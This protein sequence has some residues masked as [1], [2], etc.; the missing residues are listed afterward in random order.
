MIELIASIFSEGDFI[1]I[2]FNNSNKSVEGYIFKLLP[3]S[4]A[5][6]TLEGKLCGIKGE[7]IDSFEEG[8]LSN[9][10]SADIQNDEAPT[11]PQNDLSKEDVVAKKTDINGSIQEISPNES[12]NQSDLVEVSSSN[13]TSI[14]GQSIVTEKETTLSSFKAGDVIPLDVLH[15]IDPKLKKKN[16]ISSSQ[17]KSNGKMNTLGNDLSALMDLVKEKHEVDDLRIV[18]ALGEIKFVKPEMNF[19]FIL[20]GKSG[21]D[22]YFNISQIVEKELNSTTW[23]HAPVVY[24]L[25]NDSQD[26]GPKALTIHRPKTIHDM[27]L[28]AVECSNSGDYKHAFH[29]VEQILSEYPDN[30]SADEMRRKLER[31]YPQYY[32]KPKEFSNA[33]FKAKKY[34]NEKNYEKAIEYYLK[35]IDDKGEKLES[36]IK[37]LGMLYAYLYK[38]SEDTSLAEDYRNEAINLMSDYVEELANNIS[39]LNYLENFYYSV[40]DFENF[41]STVNHLAERR[42]IYED[43]SKHSMLL[44]KKAFALVQ[45][46]EPQEAIDTIE[47]SLSVD[48]SNQAALKLQSLIENTPDSEELLAEISATE[49]DSLNTGIS[50]FIQQTLDNYDEYAGV[51]PKIIESG[52]FNDVTLNEIRKVIETAGKARPRERAKYLLTEGKLLTDI[53]PG[54]TSRLR[55]VMARYCNAMSLNHIS[56][57]SSGDITRFYYNEAFSLEENYRKNATQIALYLMTHCCTFNELINMSTKSP[58]VDDALDR[59][60]STEFDPK[61]WESILSMFLYNREISAQITSKLYSNEHFRIQ[62]LLALKHIGL[63]D[64][65]NPISKEDFVEAWNKARDIRIRDYKKVVAQIR[66]IGECSTIEEIVTQLLGL[67]EIKADWMTSLDV[68]RIYN[69]INN[70]VPA[71]QTYIKSSGYRNKEANK[72]NANGQVQQLIEEIN[73]GPTKLSFESILPLLKRINQLI[74]I[75][76]NEIIKMSA[77]KIQI[78]LLSAETVVN[79][80]NEVSIQISISNHKDSSP[81]KEVSVDVQNTDIITTLDGGGISYNAIDGGESQI[82]KLKIKVGEDI[83]KQKA[84]ALNVRCKYKNGNEQAECSSLQTLRLYSPSDYCPIENPYAPIADGGPV[85]VDSKMFYGREEFIANIVDAII[86]SPSKQ[87]I[88]YGQKRCGKSSV[89]L[90]LKKRLLETGKTFCIFFSIGEIINNLSEASFYYKILNTIY[91]DLEFAELDGLCGHTPSFCLPSYADFKSED[92]ENP[93]NTF[94]KYMVKFKLACKHTPGWEDKNLVVMIDEFTYLY[95]EIKKGN[96]SPSIMKQWKA[97]TQNERAQFSVVLVGQDVVPSF[98]K[99]DYA[100]NAFGVIQDIRLTYLKETPA[101]DLIEKPILDE[102]GNSRYIDDAVTKIIEYTSRNPYYIQIFCARLVDYMNQNKSISVTEAD[103]IDVANSF[104]YG[105]EA[106]VEDKFDNLIRAGETEDLQE[107]PETEILQVLKQVSLN[108]KIIGFCNRNDINA[109]TDKNREDAILKHLVDREVL[110]LRGENNY[111]IQVKLFQEWLLN[112]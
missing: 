12:A 51:P 106:L 83:I 41:I 47:E 43:K 107:Y 15:Q 49:F 23:Y 67:R 11:S 2:F 103:V 60:I 91:T 75:S 4:I 89:M 32:S 36:S 38:S 42:E 8:T 1:K 72:N 105:S 66:S 46:N 100:R 87:I 22:I 112:H 35:A 5:I 85:P 33:Y 58:S 78:K 102:N 57:Y 16:K 96:I 18:P 108:S 54:N 88:I 37:D 62:A 21:K 34:H 28:I 17:K 55:S 68:S 86:K 94:T 99:E 20:D 10:V 98:K 80:G 45:L 110:E 26:Q 9:A 74:V 19:G 65:S 76:F 14:N 90:H 92:E 27:L 71:L 97:V 73:E 70:I 56:D 40:K 111:K 81:I 69:I 109:L 59:I 61:K 64:L 31:S 95:T 104:V 25:Q 44:Y 82:F 77:P 79:E 101:R 50:E 52:V 39:T 29:L 6:K 53:E 7:D 48:P 30:F 24:T 3:T 84:A 63:K 93:L 13:Q